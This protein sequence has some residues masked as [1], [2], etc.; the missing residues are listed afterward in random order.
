MLDPHAAWLAARG[1]EV[2]FNS[3]VL[4]RE[5]VTHFSYTGSAQQVLRFIRP[6][7]VAAR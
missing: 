3:A 6:L 2:D 7:C 4:Y 1:S 5:L